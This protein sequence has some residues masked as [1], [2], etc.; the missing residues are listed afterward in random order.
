MPTNQHAPS[1]VPPA[2]PWLRIC[3][4]GKAFEHTGQS[5]GLVGWPLP[6][7]GP[8]ERDGVFAEWR[9]DGNVLV[10]TND[11]YG[12]Q[13][14]FWYATDQEIAI[15]PSIPV[16]LELGAP[17]ELDATA[18]AVFL[19]LGYF[20]GED[21][22]FAAVRAL[23]PGATLTWTAGSVSID[24]RMFRGPAVSMGR[25]E[26]IDAFTERFR[27]AIA[28]RPPPAGEVLMPLS[29]GRDSRHILLELDRSGWKPAA[30]VT[31]RL[32]TGE[33]VAVAAELCRAIG[34]PHHVLEPSKSRLTNELRKNL[35]TS[36]CADEHG[37][38][39]DVADYLRGRTAAVYDGI[40]GDV[41]SAGLFLTR[42]RLDL[43]RA[44][45]FDELALRLWT[46]S[47]E[48]TLR[49]MLP[50]RSY[51]DWNAERARGRIAEELRRF[52]AEPNPVGAFF[53]ANRTR[54][55][56]ALSPYAMLRDVGPVYS[57]FLDH[58]VFDLLAG[59][60]AEMFLDGRFHTDAICRAFPHVAGIR[61]GGYGKRRVPLFRKARHAWDFLRYVGGG[62]RPGMVRPGYLWPR[63]VRHA[64]DPAY[65]WSGNIETYLIQLERLTT[66]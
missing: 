43:A 41:L 38:F 15:S 14:L 52:A 61:Y 47:K 49:A 31:K 19:R 24:S 6:G 48:A 10:V 21:T 50:A 36:F 33:D 29:G 22:P 11:R 8:D 42:E 5:T 64:I 34:V 40:G 44:G 56:I 39:M 66:R 55:E 58:D 45:A 26:A 9:W 59:L 17:G 51:G 57:P 3:R 25:D 46:E 32:P 20:L 7:R 62:K 30:C 2:V 12:F 53:F 13:P 27:R 23:P 54:R 18:L 1:S 28:K 16:L 37:W 4:R 60:P 63:A 35:L 65:R